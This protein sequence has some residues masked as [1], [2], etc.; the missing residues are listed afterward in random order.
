MILSRN[1]AAARERHLLVGVC[2]ENAERAFVH[3]VEQ[4][5][6][7]VKASLTRL[8]PRLQFDRFH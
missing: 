4:R 6:D 3:R 2:A 7:R 8:R 5:A 1:P